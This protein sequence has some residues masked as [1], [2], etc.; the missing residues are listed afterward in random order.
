MKN[1]VHSVANSNRHFDRSSGL[2]RHGFASK[3]SA[4]DVVYEL[5][6]QDP[7]PRG[8]AGSA[9]RSG[10]VPTQPAADARRSPPR[11]LRPHRPATSGARRGM[12]CL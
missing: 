11:P 3:K 2:K 1:A 4:K 5:K 10:D 9:L 12:L 8:G 6:V 7:F